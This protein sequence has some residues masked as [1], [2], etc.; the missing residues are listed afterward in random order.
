MC[1]SAGG[2]TCV[3]KS[4]SPI[5][6]CERQY[7]QHARLRAQIP[8][9]DAVFFSSLRTAVSTRPARSLQT[10]PLLPRSSYIKSL[11]T[12][13]AS[14]VEIAANGL[15]AATSSLVSVIPGTAP[16][17]FATA[18][19]A[20]HFRHKNFWACASGHAVC[21][22]YRRNPAI[23]IVRTLEGSCPSEHCSCAHE[24]PLLVQRV[25]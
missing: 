7:K 19:H 4:D 25:A 14:C 13:Y 8:A 3:I 2:R 9:S 6:G 22:I 10:T 15:R 5:G 16:I 24:T 18:Y 23:L 20:V 1:A 12:W 11:T 21:T 17:S